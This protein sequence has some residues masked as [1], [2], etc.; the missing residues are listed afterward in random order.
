MLDWSVSVLTES[1]FAEIY[2]RAY[3][4]LALSHVL[5]Q[6]LF[7]LLYGRKVVREAERTGRHRA[8]RSVPMPKR[9]VV[10]V[11]V[12]QEKKKWLE[13][14][15]AHLKIAAEHYEG[16][17]AGS[18]VT[19]MVRDDGSYQKLI[20]KYSQPQPEYSFTQKLW[21]A[22]RFKRPEN[23]AER[24]A[25]YLKKYE[26]YVG[27][28]ERY[29][30]VFDIPQLV[31][32]P[33]GLLLQASNGGKRHVQYLAW[34]RGFLLGLR[35]ELYVTVD[36]DTALDFDA[37]YRIALNFCN[38]EVG[39]AT[40]YVDVGNWNHTWLTR[41]IDMR[42]WSAFHVERAAQSFWSSV[43][44]CS[45]P[46]AAYRAQ[47]A[48]LV[49]DDYVNQMF[50]GRLCTF[51]DDRHL[52]N[53][54]LALGWLVLMDPTA[55]CLT[56]VPEKIRE[57]IPQQKRWSMSF[58]REMIWSLD[59]LQ[60]GSRFMTYD[61]TMQFVLPF[62]LIGGLIITGYLAWTGDAWATI[63]EYVGYI[64]AVGFLRSVYPFIARKPVRGR[65]DEF[66]WARRSS[67]LLFMG[68][69]VVHVC[70]LIPLRMIA[71]VSLLRGTTAW[72]TRT[73]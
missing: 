47:A 53:L 3:G 46:L 70:L 5:V 19:V 59:G 44:C 41:L 34:K 8:K 33:D 37:I 15:L 31:D 30:G 48:D 60:K 21:L 4:F 26:E 10:W 61:L 7:A 50:K 65:E 54:I 69:G 17:V 73:S 58:Y 20:E 11:P 39:A 57:Y 6:Y 43:M 67:Q 56:D 52:T 25:H 45:G 64:F 13:A 36:S 62:M 16:K 1:T 63:G 9:I 14:C 22:C 55:H 38:P 40:G 27:V 51:G 29:R 23:Y 35:A 72:G 66:G 71:L 42:Y 32:G 28:L 49:M 18:R 12:F 2:L 24:L 68:Y